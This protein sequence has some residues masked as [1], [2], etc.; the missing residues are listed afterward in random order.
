[1]SWAKVAGSEW[2][3]NQPEMIGA[4]P[5]ALSHDQRLKENNHDYFFAHRQAGL[6]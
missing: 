2:A 6:D 4:F 1:L 5:A 3:A